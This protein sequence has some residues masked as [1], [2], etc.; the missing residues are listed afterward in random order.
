MNGLT[1]EDLN[2][3]FEQAVNDG[4]RC[5]F[6]E[7]T[8]EGVREVICIPRAWFNEKLEFYNRTYT[9]ELRHIMNKRVMITSLSHGGPDQL[10]QLI[11]N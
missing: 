3:V 2:D 10:E 7:I 8:A 1:R 5:M 9:D 4:S 6:V 11:Y